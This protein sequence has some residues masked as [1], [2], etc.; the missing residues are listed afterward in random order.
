MLAGA[1]IGFGAAF[2]CIAMVGA[3]QSFGPARVL[4]SWADCS[5]EMR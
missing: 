3:D 1:F 2:S 5:W 4:V